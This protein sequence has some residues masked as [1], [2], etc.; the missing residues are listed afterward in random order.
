M[1]PFEQLLTSEAIAQ[2]VRD[3]SFD[4]EDET[5]EIYL[6]KTGFTSDQVFMA[7]AVRGTLGRLGF[8]VKD[9]VEQA[10]YRIRLIIQA[11]GTNPSIRFFGL[12]G[13]QS[14][15]L[16]LSIPELALYKRDRQDGYVR[17]YF[18]VF[19]AEGRYLTSTRSY[20]GAAQRTKYTIL[21][22]IDWTR[23]DIPEPIDREE[24]DE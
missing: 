3:I 21:F 17:F 15:L 2:G 22:F 6:E 18:D 19:D 20:E 7:D 12:P 4:L 13:S 14:A 11:L 1:T 16:P 9:S 23:S 8:V 10:K 24:L 5:A